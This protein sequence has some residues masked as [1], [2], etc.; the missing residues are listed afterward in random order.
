MLYIIKYYILLYFSAL[1]DYDELLD[2]YNKLVAEHSVTKEE[3]TQLQEGIII[4]ISLYFLSA[5]AA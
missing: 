5:S 2:K 1:K 3:L 4:S